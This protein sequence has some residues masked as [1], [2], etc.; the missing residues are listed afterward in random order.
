MIM[1]PGLPPV[2]D[3]RPPAPPLNLFVHCP[4][5]V[6]YLAELNASIP[7][8]ECYAER[9]LL[10]AGRKDVVCLTEGVEPAYLEF[11]AGLELGPAPENV[12]VASGVDGADRC[13]PL[14]QRL[15]ESPEA[16]E[17]LSALIRMHGSG[18]VHPFIVSAGQFELAEVLERR[19]GAPVRVEGGDPRVVAYA[20]F[21]HHIRA[22]AIE[23]GVPVAPGEVVDLD[24]AGGS[25]RR[26]YEILIRA[27]HRQAQATGR[28]IVRGTSG[29]AGSATFC[30]DRGNQSIQALAERL[31]GRRENR[32]Y[33]VES[34]VETTASPNIQMRID[35]STHSIECSGATDQRWERTLVHGGNLY[36]STARC[37]PQMRA[38]AH[39]LAQ[40]LCGAGFMGLAG[41]D[42]VEYTEPSGEP[43]AFLAEVNPRVNGATYP[44]GL[45]AR[46]N[47]IQ[48]DAGLPEIGAFVSG[49]VVTPADSFAALRELLDDL[50]F[51][52]GRSS[53]LVPYVTGCLPY[54]KCGMVAFAPCPVE[55][56]ELFREAGAAA[57][58]L[59]MSYPAAAFS[60]G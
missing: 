10:L 28:V 24:S 17:T 32:I 31:A 48:R 6:D 50:L 22:K 52:P 42:F 9:A 45:M 36:P 26:E 14:W 11:L 30:A 60:N 59:R 12:I 18:R 16:L 46:L 49:N 47:T 53:G 29:A 4:T 13:Q 40:W 54:G 21:K 37:I 44:L 55:A 23:L 20:D 27:I 56:D 19:S 35:G 58:G 34:M 41:F 2:S 3:S 38:W 25:S 1:S 15:L 51:S 57:A 39:T 8:V 5:S 43:R 33:L 7:G